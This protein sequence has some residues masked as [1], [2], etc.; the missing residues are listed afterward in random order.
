M[1]KS[2]QEKC[3][4]QTTDC[5]QNESEDIKNARQEKDRKRKQ[6]HHER[7][8]D[9]ICKRRQEKERV[10]KRKAYNNSTELKR[11]IKFKKSVRF[12]PIFT[13]RVC[14]Q[15][16]FENNVTVITEQF[17]SDIKS[18][19]PKL[20]ESALNK[21]HEVNILYIFNDM[22]TQIQSLCYICTTCKTHLK[23]QHLPPMASANGLQVM[24]IND[25]DLQ[26]T[27]L[28]SNLIAKRLIFQKIYKLPKSRMSA[29]KDQLINIP[30]SSEDILNT[31]EHL[32]RTPGEAGL[33]EV[34]L[35]R[36]LEYKNTHQQAYVD[37]KKI[38]KALDFL[39]A[40]GHP[41]YSFFDDYNTYRQRCK[42]SELKTVCVDI[43]S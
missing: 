42:K 35:K 40:S 22:A 38:Y 7:E 29:C 36:K 23:K 15:D 43:P 2:R 10:Q 24:P 26:L 16:M 17:E 14:E 11:L 27:E 39:K 19:S 6:E 12:G 41:E 4:K 20:Y 33:L 5:H 28:E 8:T 21:K 30:V 1:R 31:L 34:K 9:E 37:P 13:C 18:M 3:K 32:P 25:K